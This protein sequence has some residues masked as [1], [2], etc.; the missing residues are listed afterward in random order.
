M[1]TPDERSR[2]TFDTHH[3]ARFLVQPSKKVPGAVRVQIDM[4]ES[5]SHLAG[6]GLKYHFTFRHG[7]K[8]SSMLKLRVRDLPAKFDSTCMLAPRAMQTKNARFEFLVKSDDALL[9]SLRRI[10]RS[11]PTKGLCG[12]TALAVRHYP[13]QGSFDFMTPDAFEAYSPRSHVDTDEAEPE[14]PFSGRALDELGAFTGGGPVVVREEPVREGSSAVPGTGPKTFVMQVPA[15]SVMSNECEEFV[16][17]VAQ[18]CRRSGVD[19]QAL[20]LRTLRIIDREYSA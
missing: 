4:P 16:A 3:G 15:A 2:D 19:K 10:L 14:L 8:G 11:S 12:A 1:P 18:E 5:L 7:S 6:S 13:L 20:I 17:W 9:G